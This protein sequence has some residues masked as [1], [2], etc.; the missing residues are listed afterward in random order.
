LGSSTKIDG[1]ATRQNELAL[2]KWCFLYQI[3][4]VNTF[5]EAKMTNSSMTFTI[6]QKIAQNA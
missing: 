5:N 2:L 6:S 1:A 3:V 4:M